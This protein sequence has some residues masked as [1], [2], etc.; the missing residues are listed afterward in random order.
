V[1]S[2]CSTSFAL[3]ALPVG[4]LAAAVLRSCDSREL[5]YFWEVDTVYSLIEPQFKEAAL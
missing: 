3:A 5:A 2:A 1:V 4:R